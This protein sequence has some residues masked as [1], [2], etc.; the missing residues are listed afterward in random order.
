MKIILYSLNDIHA[1]AFKIFLNKNKLPYKEVN[2]NS[3]KPMTELRKLSQQNKTSALKIIFNRSIH[4][5]AGFDENYLNIN[6]LKHIK[7]YNPKIEV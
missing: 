1:K 4:V 6:L 2:V 3:E 5:I 7:K